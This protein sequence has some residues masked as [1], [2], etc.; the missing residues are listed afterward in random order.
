M[1]KTEGLKNIHTNLI[2]TTSQ[3]RIQTPPL[4]SPSSLSLMPIN[5]C[6]TPTMRGDDMAKF[7]GFLD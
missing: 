5:N 6:N 7:I 1:L 4:S 3:A 2:M